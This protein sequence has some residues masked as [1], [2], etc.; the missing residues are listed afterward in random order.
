[1]AFEK[2]FMRTL[3][4]QGNGIIQLN[5]YYL[6]FKM[7]KADPSLFHY[8]NNIELEVIITIHIDDS[9]KCRK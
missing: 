4:H 2:V 6:G 1:M 8:Q 3:M 9:F 7:S 5:K